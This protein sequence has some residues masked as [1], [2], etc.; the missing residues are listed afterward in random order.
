MTFISLPSNGDYKHYIL[1]MHQSTFNRSVEPEVY[2]LV[3]RAWWRW[4]HWTG[5]D[6]NRIQ[7]PSAR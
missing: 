3:K 1:C 6:E 5:L 7:I 2:H 4:N